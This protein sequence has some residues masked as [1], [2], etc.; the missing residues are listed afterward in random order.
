MQ[1]QRPFFFFFFFFFSES[2]LFWFLYEAW[3]KFFLKYLE[4]MYF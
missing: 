3:K 1:Y 2:A 4:P